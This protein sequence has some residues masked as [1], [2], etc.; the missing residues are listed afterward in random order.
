MTIHCLLLPDTDHYDMEFPDFG[1]QCAHKDCKQ[2]DFLPIK[3]DYCQS[4]FCKDHS[5]VDSHE[6]VSSESAVSSGTKL[7]RY[8]V[9]NYLYILF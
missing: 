6:C 9:R 8:Y 7:V 5:K 2:L 3:C 4:M 1:K